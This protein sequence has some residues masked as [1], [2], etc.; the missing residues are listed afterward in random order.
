MTFIVGTDARNEHPRPVDRDEAHRRGIV[1]R[2]VHVEILNDEKR[3]LVWHRRDGRLEIPGGH[4]DWLDLEARPESYEEASLRELEEE[5]A[6]ACNWKVEAAQ[7]RSRIAPLLGNVALVANQLPSSAGNN[8]EWVMV[9]RIDWPVA[10]GDP[11]AFTLSEDEGVSHAAWMSIEDLV[12]T[13][14][15]HPE[16][17]TSSLRLLLLRHGA[18]IPLGTPVGRE[19]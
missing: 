19:W 3:L 8:N 12:S 17:I 2:A 1:H 15:E 5:L 7:A 4:V 6:L 10:F 13:A 18:M 9:H 14:S 11:T 16:F